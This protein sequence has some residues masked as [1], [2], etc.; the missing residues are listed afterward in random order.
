VQL[1]SHATPIEETPQQR[2]ATLHRALE[3]GLDSDEVWKELAEVSL[4]IGNSDEALSCLRRIRNTTV[5]KIAASR[6][7]KMGLLADP[8]EHR[9]PAAAA[10]PA[11]GNGAARGNATREW[12]EIPGVREHLVDAIQYLLH[13]NMPWLVLVTTLAFPVLVG[14]G[15]FL[16]VGGSLL[17]LTAIAA[18]P[19]ICVVGIV[20]AMGRQILLASSGGSGDVPH[21]P[22]LGQLV[23]DAKRFQ[24]D[25]GL[26][27]IALLS[28]SIAAMSLGAPPSATVP[29][30]VVGAVFTPLASALRQVR[31]DYGALS[32]VTLLRGVARCGGGY[33][34]LAP[35]CWLLFT[36]A[37]VATWLTFGRPVWVQIAAI[38]PLCVVPVFVASRL[39]GTWL[40]T[41]RL[42]LAGVLL[43]AQAM[44][45]ANAGQ[46][47]TPVPPAVPGPRL[48]D[49][50]EALQDFVPPNVKRRQDTKATSA[51][52]RKTRTRPA[53]TRNPAERRATS[54]RP[55][56]Q[57][58]PANGRENAAP[59]P[60]RAQ[61]PQAPQPRQQPRAIE[62]RKPQHG[63]GAGLDDQPD[64]T[65]L[66]GAVVVKGD[67]RTR[68]GAAARPQG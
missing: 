12:T 50:P 36:P 23:R 17:L 61:Q 8:R 30:L 57:D 18:I 2:Y 46:R 4:R 38:G 42:D 1:E 37:A 6:L 55:A 3:R 10:A 60:R 45:K 48:P 43:G 47:P 13:Q 29:A 59:P 5:Q 14:L 53:P 34:V 68:A 49:R 19:G 67:E 66:P 52:P 51:P 26:V 15:G 56:P 63:R 7:A 24:L 58:A 11:A 27:V 20:G 65:S 31:G 40:D 41:K 44:A 22:E 39:L 28:P 54:A 33:F 35:V 62:G 21:V 64:L 16:T 9:P 25:T 32:P